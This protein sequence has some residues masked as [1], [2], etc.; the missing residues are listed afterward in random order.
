MPET[1]FQTAVLRVLRFQARATLLLY[2]IVF[3]FIGYVWRDGHSTSA[4][5][6]RESARTL[7][8][9][10]SFRADL[11]QRVSGSQQFLRDN[12]NGIPGVSKTVI[13]NGILNEQLTIQSLASLKCPQKGKK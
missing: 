11:D 3:L 4:K 12:P 6:A 10:C 2:L 7:S 1:E 5:I 9:L 13:E 8:A